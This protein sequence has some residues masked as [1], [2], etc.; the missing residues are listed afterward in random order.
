MRRRLGVARRHRESRS[1]GDE[2]LVD[3]VLVG[4]HLA[5]ADERAQD[6]DGDA[7]RHQRRDVGAVV[8]GRHLHHLHSTESFGCDEADHLE[9]LAGQQA[10]R[11]GPACAGDEAGLDDVY[12]EREVDGVASIPRPRQRH[13]DHLGRPELLHVGD[14]EDVR[15]AV[16][17]DG[18]CRAGNLPASDADL[19]QVLRADVWKVGGV[20]VWRGMHALVQVRLL[21]V[22][23]P[24]K[25]DDADVLGGA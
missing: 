8:R 4:T 10:A 23:V 11:L 24:V 7:Q 12:V 18:H 3:D 15:A 17:H 2:G 20:E 25:V 19:H 22:C 5:V 9:G 6:V 21:N 1:K 16:A 14:G 13:L